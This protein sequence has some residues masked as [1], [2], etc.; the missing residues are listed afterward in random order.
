MPFNAKDNNFQKWENVI[1][2]VQGYSHE[3]RIIEGQ[4]L[5]TTDTGRIQILTLDRYHP[6]KTRI[7]TLANNWCFPAPK[8]ET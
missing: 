8:K 1:A 4:Y 5:G 3:V 6:K 7:S 2:V